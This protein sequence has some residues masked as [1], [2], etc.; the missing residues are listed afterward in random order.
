VF[1][2]W[3]ANAMWV[4]VVIAVSTSPIGTTAPL[5]SRTAA[6]VTVS[7]IAGS[8]VPVPFSAV[9]EQGVLTCSPTSHLVADSFWP[10]LIKG[11]VFGLSRVDLVRHSARWNERAL[12]HRTNRWNT[13]LEEVLA[14]DAQISASPRTKHRG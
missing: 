12:S 4:F 1:L 9:E 10:A 11:Q 8:L 2:R 6:L 5:P 3:R 14:V 13:T 7:N